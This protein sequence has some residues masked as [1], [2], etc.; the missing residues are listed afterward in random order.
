MC[1]LV[2]RSAC[3]GVREQC[4]RWCPGVPALVSGSACAGVRECLR[5]CP[6]GDDEASRW[7]G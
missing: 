3:A 4:L 6:G 5:W 1:A 2:S 7:V